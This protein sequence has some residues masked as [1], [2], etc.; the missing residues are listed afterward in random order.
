MTLNFSWKT[1]GKIMLHDMGLIE[2]D[3]LYNEIDTGY[4]IFKEAINF[5]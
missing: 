1:D 4:L 5:I 2:N 3:V